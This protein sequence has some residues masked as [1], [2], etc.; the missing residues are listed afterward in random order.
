MLHDEWAGD[1]A[2]MDALLLMQE[3]AGPLSVRCL[4]RQRVYVTRVL[5]VRLAGGAV[6]LAMGAAYDLDAARNGYRS[7]KG[8][9]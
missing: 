5:T 1:D 4:N 8:G 7:V 3:V 9:R 6:L 2:R